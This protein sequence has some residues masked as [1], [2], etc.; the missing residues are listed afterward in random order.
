MTAL[1]LALFAHLNA[2]LCYHAK[3]SKVCSQRLEKCSPFGPTVYYR[4]AETK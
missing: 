2:V 1:Y 4:R 3:L